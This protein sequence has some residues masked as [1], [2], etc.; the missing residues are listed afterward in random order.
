MK[1]YV[2]G[3]IGDFLQCSWF[4]ANNKT[5]EFIVHTHFKQAESFF[6]SLGAENSSFYYFNNI[7][8]HDAQIDKIIENH[9]ENSTTNIRE[10]PRA[11]YS[12]INFSQ[13][14]KENAKSFV[15]KFQNNNPVIGIH[16]FGSSFSSDTYSKFN[17]PP[18]YIPSDVI[19]NVISDE[20]NYVIF[21]SASE[22]ENYGVNQSKNVAHTNMNVESCLE[23]VKLCHKFIG[24]DSGFKTMSSMSRIATIC[25]LGDFDDKTRDQYFI[26]QYEKDGVIKVFR[27]KNMKEQRGD[28]IKFLKI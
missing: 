24:T 25:V 12:D 19:N 8:E 23:L 10:C 26:N 17:L 1:F 5:K 15:E 6:K 22:L 13:E 20:F 21:G 16:P 4:I 3:G 18:K 14:S 2:R 9:G 11:F 27:L 7:E 28:L